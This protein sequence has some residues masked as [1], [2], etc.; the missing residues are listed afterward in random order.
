MNRALPLVLLC[1]ALNGSAA[2]AQSGP[3]AEERAACRPDAIK[4]CASAVGKPAQMNTCL[5]DNKTR[6]SE[7]CR[8]VVDAHAG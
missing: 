5:R 1:L 6:L 2:L 8:K 4:F 7:S 3:T